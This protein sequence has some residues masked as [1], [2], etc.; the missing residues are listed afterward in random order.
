[1]SAAHAHI[2]KCI[3][4]IEGKLEWGHSQDWTHQD[5]I[6]LSERIQDETGDSISYITLKRIW[7]KVTYNSLPNLNTLDTLAHFLGYDSWRSYQKNVGQKSTSSFFPLD[8]LKKK[9]KVLLQAATLA[10][11]AILILLVIPAAKDEPPLHPEDFSFSSK[12]IIGS[13]IPNSVVFN[14]DAHSSPY[15]S[16]EVQQS[17]DARLRTQIPKDQTQ[18]TS[19]YYYPGFFEAK[20]VV[21]GQIMQ[22]HNLHITSNGW[23]AAIK[24]DPVPVYLP[25]ADLQKNGQLEVHQDQ[26]LEKNISLQPQPPLFRIGNVRDFGDLKTDN[27]VFETTF[28]HT[29]QEGS[30]ACQRTAVYLLC[31]GRIILIPFS[32]KGCISASNLF[33]INHYASG[34]EK[35]LSAFGVDFS[36]D[37]HLKIVSIAGDASIYLDGKKIYTILEKIDPVS[38][39]GIDFR[40]YGLGSV[41]EVKLGKPGED[42]IL[43]DDFE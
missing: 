37:V 30:A 42:W 23:Y 38:I 15:D 31:E 2:K 9:G 21:G 43:N 4:A 8:F 5:F 39:K 29:Y 18:H 33:F 17:W 32:A 6:N 36:N 41:S 3:E 26:V 13:G 35:D 25:I 40:F 24:Q 28:R 10:T 34:K 14:L 22:E 1:M 7:G 16:V 19:I 12:K 20:L 27:F 11:I